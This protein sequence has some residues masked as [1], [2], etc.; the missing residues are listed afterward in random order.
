MERSYLKQK[1]V[2]A[3]KNSFVSLLELMWKIVWV[4]DICNNKNPDWVTSEKQKNAPGC[5]DL[6]KD[7]FFFFFTIYNRS[8]FQTS[9][10][11]LCA[12]C[13]K[14]KDYY[15]FKELGASEVTGHFRE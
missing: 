7:F 1:K 11:L 12:G 15:N 6:G 5:P 10:R 8:S 3:L 14:H 2:R 13:G 4:T 9:Y